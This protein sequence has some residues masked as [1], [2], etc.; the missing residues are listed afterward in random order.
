M[1]LIDD[2]VISVEVGEQLTL[3]CEATGT[4]KPT[5]ILLKGVFDSTRYNR[6]VGQRTAVSSKR[7]YDSVQKEDA[8]LYVC[9]AYNFLVGPPGGK[10]KVTDRK[11]ITV[12]VIG[13]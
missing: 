4:P 13:E 11:R 7:I 1:P 9:Y 5:V 3:H 6:D 12:E 10:R 2:E 8:G